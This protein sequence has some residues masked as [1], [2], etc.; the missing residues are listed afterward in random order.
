MIRLSFAILLFLAS[1]L[2]GNG[3]TP[4]I[5]NYAVRKAAISKA[6]AE[7]DFSTALPL[8]E[9][10]LSALTST[11]AYDSLFNYVYDYGLTLWKTEGSATAADKTD[12]LLN[13]IFLHDTDTLHWL[14][15]LSHGSNIFYELRDNE[16]RDRVDLQ[17][18]TLAE[19]CSKASHL[20]RSSG[21][22]NMGFN[23]LEVGRAE[24]AL[25]HFRKA[26]EVID[27]SDNEA[28]D[29]LVNSYNALGAALWRTGYMAEAKAA[30]NNCIRFIDRLENEYERLGNRSNC[31]GNLSLI[32]QDEG[33][34]ITAKRY[35]LTAIE[36]RKKA[37]QIGDDPF[38]NQQHQRMLASN[39]RNLAAIYLN[40]GD[41][42]RALSITEGLFK[43]QQDLYGPDHPGMAMTDESFGS[44]YLNMGNTSKALE[45]LKRYLDYCEAN[46]G[47]ESFITADVYKRIGQAYAQDDQHL[48]AVEAFSE[49]IAIYRQLDE[50]GMQQSLPGCFAQRS[51]A[52]QQLNFKEKALADS[53][54]VILLLQKQR[55]AYDP[56]LGEAYLRRSRLLRNFKMQDAAEQS[57][58][59]ALT[60][61][62]AYRK[63]L[64]KGQ[65]IVSQDPVLFLPE[66]YVEK[67]RSTLERAAPNNEHQA[68]L[69]LDS[70]LA[71]LR[72]S[73]NIYDGQEAQL[74]LYGGH[75]PA[76]HLAQDLCFKQYQKT[77][78]PLF[79]K[80]MLNLSEESKTLL[81]RRQLQGIGSVQFYQVPDS[82][83]NHERNLLAQLNGRIPLESGTDYQQLEESYNEL[84]KHI[85]ENYPDYYRFQIDERT[86]TL[87]DIRTELLGQDRTLVQ[88]IASEEKHYALVVNPNSEYLIE[89]STEKL[90]M[91]IEHF[92]QRITD[93]KLEPFVETSQA[94]FHILIEPI[95]D[96][97][98][99]KELLIVPDERLFSINFETLIR[100]MG[101]KSPHYLIYDYTFSYLLSATTAVNFKRLD[102][103]G[104]KNLLALAPGF[105]DELKLSYLQNHRDTLAVD[106]PYLHYL[107][108][109]F[110]VRSAQQ[111]ANLMSGNA[112]TG[113]GATEKRFK[114]EASQY[115]VIHLGTHTEINNTSPM[116]SRLI[117][118][119]NPEATN[120]DDD[121]YL[122]VYEIYNLSLRAELAVLSACETG[123]GQEHPTEGV[124]SL[125]QS[126]AYA[127]C[128]SIVMSLWQ[129]DEKTSSTIIETFYRELRNGRTKN[130]A[131]R[132]AKLTYLS[133]NTGE[134][135]APYFWAG[136]VLLGNTEAIIKPS[137][138]YLWF[139]IAAA[140]LLLV[141]FVRTRT[142]KQAKAS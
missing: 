56:I 72:N 106:E 33:Q 18:L 119:K 82:I 66:A 93:L 10:Q 99:T 101:Q 140:L 59:S 77:F 57:L 79:L 65:E 127:G 17:F 37:L 24:Q 32:F 35:L 25:F 133:K 121:G 94:L 67:A 9:R 64:R 112:F 78:E 126:F 125:S 54:Q 19:E 130:E 51:S 89:L 71:I 41:Y 46:Y 69:Y 20:Q 76:F 2:E 13:T 104:E 74:E 85:A 55:E 91:L 23:F 3:Q 1:G 39:F 84:R 58:D 109:P 81:L 29:R 63:N 128:P 86:A 142:V 47:H 7:E 49:A 107:Q 16:K 108:Q 44:I 129:I 95:E 73:K 141:V 137:K 30:F 117:L 110:A 98:A 87:E 96:L 28:N 123:V 50:D 53:R 75:Q 134:L 97:I 21:H 60:I 43:M 113:E 90:P 68:A 31:L 36:D 105:S 62:R 132:K 111:V 15:A 136:M 5:E 135:S 138:N 70:A 100:P 52:Y 48:A 80:K 102:R 45:Y 122:H 12:Q 8:L 83:V 116:L 118:A 88:Y 139:S 120:S 38:Q 14:K 92:N 34:L 40:M 103:E 114:E 124:L 22:Y 11:E 61:L 131:L 26:V 4:A 42:S 6:I 115:R 27:T